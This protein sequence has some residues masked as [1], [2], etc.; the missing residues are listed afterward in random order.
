MKYA[1]YELIGS[2][3]WCQGTYLHR[4]EAEAKA[5]ELKAKGAERTW[6]RELH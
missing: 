2:G 5:A 1:V 4:P 3:W 6:I